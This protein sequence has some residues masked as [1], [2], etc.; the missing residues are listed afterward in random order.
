[1]FTAPT[2]LLPRVVDARAR[3][4]FAP[5]SFGSPNDSTVVTRTGLDD[6]AT[7][8]LGKVKPQGMRRSG[9]G[10]NVQIASIPMSV[11]DDWGVASDGTVVFV[12]SDGYY[13][14]IVRPDGSTVTGPRQDVDLLRPSD[15]DKVANL[16]AG[17]A[18]GLRMAM[19]INNGETQMSMSRGGRGGEPDITQSEWPSRMPAFR[20]GSTAVAPDGRIFVGRSVHAGEPAL[21]DVFNMDGELIGHTEFGPNSSIVGFGA[22]GAI[23]IAE[24]DMF[25]L[26]YLKK[27]TVG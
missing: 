4:Y 8:A 3:V 22:N 6:E 13:L 26:Q 24:T 5:R 19:T 10:G 17:A 15:A 9:S 23:Y 12:R 2:M 16:E 18:G 14:E 7:T 11:Q 21:F 25:G 27:V 1:M 20:A